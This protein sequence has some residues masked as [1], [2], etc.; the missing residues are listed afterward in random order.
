M[1]DSA[2]T[3]GGDTLPSF[4]T[5]KIT[6]SGTLTLT[7]TQP[8]LEVVQLIVEGTLSA[9]H[10]LTISSVLVDVTGSVSIGETLSVE[11][12]MFT[13]SGTSQISGR[14]INITALGNLTVTSQATISTDGRGWLAAQG[15]CGASVSRDVG[16]GGSHGGSGSTWGN[17]GATVNCTFGDAVRPLSWGGGS[18]RRHVAS[19]GLP[20]GGALHVHAT[21]LIVDG[22]LSSRG[23]NAGGQHYGGGGGGSV[24]IVA[25]ELGGSGV[26]S[27]RGGRGRDY[28]GGGGGGRIG[29]QCV[30]MS[31]GGVLDASGGDSS[32]S[33]SWPVKRSGGTGSVLVDEIGCGMSASS[34]GV[35]MEYISES[36]RVRTLSFVQRSSQLQGHQGAL[37]RVG[38]S[39]DVFIG[40]VDVVV[41]DAALL[42][43]D[44]IDDSVVADVRGDSILEVV[45]VGWDGVLS[46]FD[47]VLEGRV[48]WHGTRAR[49][50]GGN[51]AGLVRLVGGSSM[52]SSSGLWLE[53]MDGVFVDEGSFVDG[54]SV[55]ISG[56]VVNVSGVVSTNGRGWPGAKGP[57]RAFVA[58]GGGGHGGFGGHISLS[59]RPV[60][61]HGSAVSAADWGSGGD[62]AGSYGGGRISIETLHA[63]VRGTLRA[64][65]IV[66]AGSR[67]GGGAGGS[68][69]VS[70]WAFTGA[71]ALLASG[72]GKIDGGGGGGRVSVVA[73][74]SSEF[75]GAIMVYGG[76]RTFG[77]SGGAGSLAWTVPDAIADV[78]AWSTVKSVSDADLL[79]A[80]L[81]VMRPLGEPV[82]RWRRHVVF[83]GDGG[84]LG[85][86]AGVGD[87]RLHIMERVVLLNDAVLT[88][89]PGAGLQA[90]VGGHAGSTLRVLAGGFLCLF[91]LPHLDDAV[92]NVTTDI[93]GDVILAN[94]A[95]HAH[96]SY[97]GGWSISGALT[98]GTVV[99]CRFGE[100][101]MPVA[102]THIS[103]LE[104]NSVGVTWTNF[105]CRVPAWPFGRLEVGVSVPMFVSVRLMTDTSI[106]T[107]FI[108]T[109]LSVHYDPHVRCDLLP[110]LDAQASVPAACADLPGDGTCDPEC[111][112]LVCAWD[113]RDCGVPNVYVSP[114]GSDATQSGAREAPFATVAAAVSAA[115]RGFREC[116]TVVL[117]PGTHLVTS[118]LSLAN[119]HLVLVGDAPLGAQNRTLVQFAAAT[120]LLVENVNLTLRDV[121]VEWPAMA[122]VGHELTLHVSHS[123][124]RQAPSVPFS[125][126]EVTNSEVQLEEAIIQG[127]GV[128][129]LVRE[130]QHTL[131]CGECE[132]MVSWCPRCMVVDASRPTIAEG[133]AWWVRV[134]MSVS[135]SDASVTA[136][137]GDDD[138]AELV[139]FLR[140]DIPPSLSFR[141]AIH[142]DFVNSSITGYSSKTTG[143]AIAL[144]THNYDDNSVGMVDTSVLRASLPE[145]VNTGPTVAASFIH[146]AFRENKAFG[147]GGAIA[148]H[149][150]SVRHVQVHM[151]DTLFAKNEARTHGGAVSLRVLVEGTS[152]SREAFATAP[153]TVVEALG[154]VASE[155]SVEDSV[156]SGVAAR[157]RLHNVQLESNSAA[158]G[159]GGVSIHNDAPLSTSAGIA[160]LVSD[161]DLRSNTA[162][163]GGA[164]LQA[165]G[166]GGDGD[167]SKATP[168]LRVVVTSSTLTENAVTGTGG[169]GVVLSHAWLLLEQ[170][171]MASQ[172]GGPVGG[173]VYATTDAL[174]VARSSSFTGSQAAFG[175]SISLHSLSVGNVTRC[176]F[177]ETSG[178]T[179]G[180]FH[181]S[182]SSTL[183]VARSAFDGAEANEGGVGVFGLQSAASFESC[184]LVNNHANFDASVFLAQ[185]ASALS[186]RNCTVRF[187][188]AGSGATVVLRSGSAAKLS[189]VDLTDNHLQALDPTRPSHA[190]GV[191]CSLSS[192]ELGPGVV[193]ARNTPYSFACAHCSVLRWDAVS[194]AWPP[195]PISCGTSTTAPTVDGQ[196]LRG[197]GGRGF[198]TRGGDVAAI[199]GSFWTTPL[200]LSTGSTTQRHGGND[201]SAGVV[202]TVAGVLSP[203]VWLD[204]RPAA[205]AIGDGAGSGDV[206]GES[207]A[208]TAV[209]RF[210]V[211]PGSGTRRPVRVFLEG[212]PPFQATVGSGEPL[213]EYGAPF[214]ATVSPDIV[215][216]GGSAITLSGAN[217]GTP[218]DT[219]SVAVVVLR[220]RG[221][222]TSVVDATADCAMRSTSG[223]NVTCDVPQGL[224]LFSLR[225]QVGSRTT[226]FGPL[227]QASGLQLRFVSPATVVFP[228]GTRVVRDRV[229]DTMPTQYLLPSSAAVGSLQPLQPALRIVLFHRKHGLAGVDAEFAA[230]ATCE[231]DVDSPV[232]APNARVVGPDHVP[233]VATG[234]G[235]FVATFA[236]GL[237]AALN[238]TSFVF[239]TCSLPHS[240]EQLTSPPVRVRVVALRTTWQQRIVQFPFPNAVLSQPV[241]VALSVQTEPEDVW[242]PLTGAWTSAVSCVLGFKNGPYVPGA[243]VSSSPPLAPESMPVQP[244]AASGMALFH[245]VRV[246]A[247]SSGAVVVAHVACATGNVPF[248]A[249]TQ[250]VQMQ[251]I[252][253]VWMRD[254]DQTGDSRMWHVVASDGSRADS[255]TLEYVG[256]DECFVFFLLFC[257]VVMCPPPPPPPPTARA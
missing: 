133:R 96:G 76:S 251:T 117:L 240:G 97:L 13:L 142:V 7:G 137:S 225:V 136:L 61:S 235:M 182:E 146:C 253:P 222:D 68:I 114:F 132:V 213:L 24:W 118:S 92:T 230:G 50:R 246:V 31:F 224:G 206:L 41:V 174:V 107:D 57:C 183:A 101:G 40:T 219:S 199:T 205:S 144:V 169:G 72:G 116:A 147:A 112:A 102:A 28:G 6:S 231:L 3:L 220:H 153:F 106:T 42:V 113:G 59:Q 196:L 209:I 98:G 18:G 232:S 9:Q 207:D 1:I 125:L 163:R 188:S 52:W 63:V 155:V 86:P 123:T 191:S 37:S 66:G 139:S 156:G 204:K 216:A 91:G 195:T 186:L 99:S 148:I 254:G 248:P 127:V 10:S 71:G 140:V 67:C 255:S 189:H 208:S 185:Q 89:A 143:G 201:T 23:S 212:L 171:S 32:W 54:R 249:V 242:T 84:Y 135:G 237:E 252:E 115:C 51:G 250:G 34:V 26:V 168:T 80:G 154:T 256:R 241:S 131:F 234:N 138:A 192:M 164:G 55:S 120:G 14:T 87:P 22:S 111:D 161:S 172:Y 215:P 190:A 218:R 74:S 119:V 70:T 194:Q 20:G 88:I 211:P 15:P 79:A 64:N 170:V 228:N 149:A 62:C 217:L 184:S 150:A 245:N 53:G 17:A 178:F 179:G 25:E 27:V 203:A 233:L 21:V 75:E 93:Q 45:E 175:A 90:F 47:G 83:D 95:T 105:T 8:H 126:M 152:S 238:S 5:L 69:R 243:D 187:N 158:L 33:S 38:M 198:S 151:E 11:A 104:P 121:D 159:G 56:G 223:S 49:V 43:V 48:V 202:V 221:T 39:A 157:L 36:C 236:A 180:V 94:L 109:N 165:T 239:A 110:S 173:D 145:P 197:A 162:G 4:A 176:R 160:C 141:S 128:S 81:V 19:G 257:E 77:A 2:T 200:L 46:L 12:H 181:V 177:L 100:Y 193:V 85:S 122:I 29:I 44:R 134:G 130:S 58:R 82:S 124:L 35:G 16:F 244:Y 60:C 78:P 108:K 30:N 103:T 210:Q 214:V 73:R 65:G 226:S 247:P 229:L 227:T 166:A 167:E 129:I